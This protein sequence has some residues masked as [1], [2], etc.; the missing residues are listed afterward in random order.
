MKRGNDKCP[1]QI[2]IS[3]H[4]TYLRTWVD[5]TNLE[6]S[7]ERL[8][9]PSHCINISIVFIDEGDDLTND[10]EGQTNC[11]DCEI[12]PCLPQTF[13]GQNELGHPFTVCQYVYNSKCIRKK[14]IEGIVRAIINALNNGEY[15]DPLANIARKASVKELKSNYPKQNNAS[16]EE[17]KSENKKYKTNNIMEHI[18]QTIKLTESDLHKIIKESVKKVLKEGPSEDGLNA[19]KE[20]LIKSFSNLSDNEKTFLYDLLNR[21]TWEVVYTA[22]RILKPY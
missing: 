17:L 14:Y 12:I 21:E 19:L 11:D 5:R 6:N 7:K 13:N 8:Q 16:T 9:D 1:V 2:R 10:C 15:K 22:L 20:V 3:N 18:K 4:G